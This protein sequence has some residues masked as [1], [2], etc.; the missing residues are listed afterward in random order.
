MRPRTKALLAELEAGPRVNWNVAKPPKV[1][2]RPPKRAPKPAQPLRGLQPEKRIPW[3]VE[4]VLAVTPKTHRIWKAYPHVR[5]AWAK[6]RIPA[7]ERRSKTIRTLMH[8]LKRKR[9]RERLT[10]WRSTTKR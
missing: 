7:M 2:W 1:K 8:K 9:R 6:E 3:T 10:A 4:R 5:E